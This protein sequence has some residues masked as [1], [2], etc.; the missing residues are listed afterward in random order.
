MD[1]AS[2]AHAAQLLDKHL[3]ILRESREI[4]FNTSFCVMKQFPCFV[5]RGEDIVVF[6]GGSSAVHQR[7]DYSHTH[8]IVT[9][10]S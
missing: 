10:L 6:S 1:A 3:E 2:G 5:K 4:I 9:Q 7:I 8:I